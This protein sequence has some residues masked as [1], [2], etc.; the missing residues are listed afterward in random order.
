MNE[1]EVAAVCYGRMKMIVLMSTFQDE[2]SGMAFCGLWLY[3][4][5]LWTGADFF[6]CLFLFVFCA[7]TVLESCFLH[8][9]FFSPFFQSLKEAS[10]N[11]FRSTAEETICSEQLAE[12]FCSASFDCKMY[13]A[14]K[15]AGE[16]VRMVRTS[17]GS[18]FCCCCFVL[19]LSFFFL[20]FF[21]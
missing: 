3:C 2:E 8:Y 1:S 21:L 17:V 13:V 14:G 4:R 18:F 19:S 11:L 7:E 12:D 15:K 6:F 9:F 10:A 20:F 16:T 5:T